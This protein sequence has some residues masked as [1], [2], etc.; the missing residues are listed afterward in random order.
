MSYVSFGPV[1]E[2]TDD[3]N[4]TPISAAQASDYYLNAAQ[5]VLDM[6]SG[7]A[8]E[9]DNEEIQ[10]ML[11]GAEELLAQAFATSDRGLRTA[12]SKEVILT[13]YDIIAV[14]GKK[15]TYGGY[16][17]DFRVLLLLVVASVAAGA[18]SVVWHR[19]SK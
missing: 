14:L 3:W 2:Y 10:S 13:C 4:I 7:L 5:H 15:P 16:P 6:A 17:I 9:T 18:L 11:A 19:G 12:L 1:P 8:L